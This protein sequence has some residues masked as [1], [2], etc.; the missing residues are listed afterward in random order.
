MSPLS[1]I[2]VGWIQPGA[3]SANPI[4]VKKTGFPSGRLPSL[5]SRT[6]ETEKA[7]IFP[8]FFFLTS[9]Q[10]LLKVVVFPTSPGCMHFTPLVGSLE[11]RLNCPALQGSNIS[12]TFPRLLPASYKLWAKTFARISTALKQASGVGRL[13]CCQQQTFLGINL[14]FTLSVFGRFTISSA[15]CSFQ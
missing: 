14:K 3:D 13:V 9:F 6:S 1:W 11:N 5:V 15:V 4:C 8:F 2:W 12:V 7:Y 10:L